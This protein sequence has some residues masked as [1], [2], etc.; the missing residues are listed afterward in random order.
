MDLTCPPSKAERQEK[1][2]AERQ[3]ERNKVPGSTRPV[4][5]E[6]KVAVGFGEIILRFLLINLSRL[7]FHNRGTGNG[8]LGGSAKYDGLL[9]IGKQS[10]VKDERGRSYF[11]SSRLWLMEPVFVSAVKQFFNKVMHCVVIR[12]HSVRHYSLREIRQFT[13]SE[14]FLNHYDKPISDEI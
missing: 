5:S 4:Q 11:W 10:N 9:F 7:H 12:G 1:Q 2:D 3:R 13:T 14:W 8:A 6:S